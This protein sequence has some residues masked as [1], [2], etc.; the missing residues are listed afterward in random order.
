M[1]S[2]GIELEDIF[3][4]L[5]FLGIFESFV[6]RRSKGLIVGNSLGACRLSEIEAKFFP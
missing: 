2:W 6:I 4:S 5:E 1:T 3:V